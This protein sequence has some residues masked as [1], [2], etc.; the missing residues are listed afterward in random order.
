MLGELSR[1]L[2]AN[3]NQVDLLKRQAEELKV[4]AVAFCSGINTML[5]GRGRRRQTQAVHNSTGFTLRRFNVD[6][7]KGVCVWPWAD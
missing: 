6:I 5:T 3:V 2:T 7:S 4:R 1:Q